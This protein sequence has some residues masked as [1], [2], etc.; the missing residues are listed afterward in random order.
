MVQ[1][2]PLDAEIAD[3]GELTLQYRPAVSIQVNQDGESFTFRSTA[4][5]LGLALFQEGIRIHGGDSITPLQGQKIDSNLEV[6]LI[7]AR[8]IE[9]TADGVTFTTVSSAETVSQAL[10][11]AGVTLQDLDYTKPAER[12]P[13][14]GDGKIRV[15]RVTEE[16]L[17]ERTTI[18]Y[19]VRFVA[20]DT[21]EVNQ[22]VVV[23][24]GQAGVKA[25]RVRVRYEDGVEVSRTVGEEITLSNPVARVINYGS[26]VTD[27]VMN[28]PNGPITYYLA[29]DVIATSYSPCRS[30]GSTCYNKAYNGM[31]VEQGVIGVNRAW[32]DI[33]GG[34]TD[35]CARLWCGN[36][37]G[38]R[39]LPGNESLDRPGVFG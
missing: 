1:L 23:E 33:F 6:S 9:I 2:Y 34:I 3:R 17:L 7:S 16:L 26:R 20:D 38:H 39:G 31:T 37:R 15:V 30:G 19:E 22:R 8:P 36:H 27:K 18:P 21:L 32:Y 14:P 35:L 10:Q 25:S 12:N 28:T 5:T 24:E 13:I 11:A 29:L 4:Q